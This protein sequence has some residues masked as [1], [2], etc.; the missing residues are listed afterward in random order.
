MQETNRIDLFQRV[1]SEMRRYLAYNAKLK[2][3]Y[4]SVMNFVLKE[5]LQWSNLTPKNPKPFSDP[6]RHSER[7]DMHLA[8]PQVLTKVC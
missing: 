8:V 4:G 5:R 2:K 1:P 3:E 6:G 7:V